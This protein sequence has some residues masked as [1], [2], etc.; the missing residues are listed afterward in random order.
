M[1]GDFL[2]SCFLKCTY[3]DA[4][5]NN[6]KIILQTLNAPRACFITK[7]LGNFMLHC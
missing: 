1:G 7:A 2:C 4:L 5:E 3:K 6:C